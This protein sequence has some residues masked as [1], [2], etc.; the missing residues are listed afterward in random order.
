[1]RR[2]LIAVSVLV[3]LATA[4]PA[5]HGGRVIETDKNNGDTLVLRRGQQLSVVLSSTYWQFQSS[6]NPAVL[7]PEG[8]PQVNPQLPPGSGGC[9]P[10]QGCG[11][12]SATFL[13]I[14]A[15][16]V[17]VTATRTTCGEALRCIGA[18]GRFSLQVIVQP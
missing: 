4:C 14:A 18:N 10:G 6:S 16:R 13:A 9:V 17:T 7:R 12:A 8:R 15:G 3:L 11:A 2:R 1:M 5:T